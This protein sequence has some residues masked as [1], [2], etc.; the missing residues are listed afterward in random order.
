MER[1]TIN[2]GNR[3]TGEVTVSGA[4][5]AAVA[6]I[7][8]TIL[9]DDICR[10]ENIP[11]ITDVSNM[12]HILK[13]MGAKI[14]YVDRSTVEIDSRPIATF[15]AP[16]E[17][18][19]RMRGSAY[20]M[21]A[22]LGRFHHAVVA[23]PGGCNFGV[24]P[25]DQHLKG[26]SAL[27]A[28]YSLEGGMVDVA[29]ENL[30]GSS[31]Y[32]DVVSVGATINIML[33]AVKAEG[34]TVIENAAREPHI[35][36]LANFLNSMG[37]DV[38]GAGTDEIKIRGCK[39]LHGT[40]YSIIP[41]QIEAGTYMV[42]A[43]ATSGDVL[44]KNVIPKHLDSITAKLEEIGVK[45]EEYDDSIRVSRTGPLNKCTIKTMPHPGF[46]T[47]MHP[48]MAVLLSIASGTSIINESIFDNRFQYVDEL[49]RLGAHISVEG[50]LA[51]IE[52]VDHLTGAIVKATDLRAGVAM[53]I[54]GLCARGVTQVEDIQYIERGYEDIVGKLRSLGA[55]I[56]RTAVPEPSVPQA[57]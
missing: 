11:N 27:G 45:V 46:P 30:C 35:V 33:A 14:R 6:I 26:F 56:R 10:I 38:R 43:A 13:E 7:P 28:S 50:R 9:C 29:A 25:I 32:L 49:S 5:N 12:L 41:D 40:V 53:L 24:R 4:K 18:V 19:R 48:Q 21:G 34:T 51:V 22:F 31:V 3:L 17:L 36:D 37:A 15:V 55:D 44:I 2:G 47:D 1:F 52:G 39:H 8:A 57:I 42:A 23:M 20:L 16:Y 54:A